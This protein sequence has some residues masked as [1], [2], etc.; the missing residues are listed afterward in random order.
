MKLFAGSWSCAADMIVRLRDLV[1]GLRELGLEQ[2]PVIVHSSLRSFGQVEGGAETV[3]SALMTTFNTV[4]VPTFT[5]RTMLI[6]LTGPPDNG[7]TYG[8][9]QDRNEQA[10]F[11][12]L[13]MPADPLMGIVPETLRR[14]PR[15]RR[16]FPFSPDHDRPPGPA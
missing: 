14:H 8:S 15:A 3:V 10:E 6:P 12:T 13:K 7:L 9:M 11:F 16:T 2:V 5:Y 4:L 1:L